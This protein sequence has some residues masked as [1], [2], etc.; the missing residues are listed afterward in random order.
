LHLEA[1]ARGAFGV[2]ADRRRVAGFGAYVKFVDAFAVEL[3]K[4]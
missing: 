4:L 1:Q 3:E 2:P